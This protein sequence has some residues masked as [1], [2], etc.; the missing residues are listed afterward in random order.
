MQ[1]NH[2]FKTEAG[3]FHLPTARQTEDNDLNFMIALS[4]LIACVACA[5]ILAS[6]IFG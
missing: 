6:R 4:T 1:D 5:A 3:G 2:E